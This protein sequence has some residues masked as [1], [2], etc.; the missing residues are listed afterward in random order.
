M[1]SKYDYLSLKSHK[2]WRYVNGSIPKPV[3]KL[4]PKATTDANVS[5]TTVVED[6]YEARL[7]EWESIQSKIL[8]WFINTFVPSIHSLLP[9]LGTIAA[10]WI[11][12]SNRYNC[13]NDSS[14]EFHI[15][16]KVYQM[17]QEIG[18]SISDYYSQTS[19]MWEQLS[20]ADPPLL[21]LEDI[22]LFAKYWDCHQFMHFMMGLSEDFE[23]TRAF[24]LNRSPTPSLDVAVKELISKKNF[25]P[26]YHMSSFDHVLAMPP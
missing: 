23:P 7:E 10:A 14:L 21:Y 22:E 12:M 17:H 20:A 2:L 19:S 13:T 4:K 5:K 25:W 9:H 1:V 3:P 24:L 16:S 8:S 26:A 15:E 11:F 18:Q 6:D